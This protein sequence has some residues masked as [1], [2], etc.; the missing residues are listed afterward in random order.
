MKNRIYILFLLALLSNYVNTIKRVDLDFP[1]KIDPDKLR[2]KLTR[3]QW[4]VTQQKFTENPIVGKFAQIFDHGKYHCVV[5]DKYVFSSD[6][7]FHHQGYAAFE[8]A[9]DNVVN[10]DTDDF[11]DGRFESICKNC[12]SYF[13]LSYESSENR[14]EYKYL[15]NSA[16]LKFEQKGYK[17]S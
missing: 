2:K 3:T 4:G 5:C 17:T 11:S 15:I 12:G 16:A 13:G 7:K 9:T 8:D 1:Y 10:I 14:G 6:H